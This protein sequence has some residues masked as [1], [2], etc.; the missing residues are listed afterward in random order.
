MPLKLDMDIKKL[1]GER[2]IS[3]EFVENSSKLFS[4]I[5]S[6]QIITNNSGFARELLE[7][8]GF[9]DFYPAQEDSLKEVE[10]IKKQIGKEKAVVGFGGGKA[11]DV[12]KKVSSDLNL[13]FIS[14]PTAPSH[15]GLVS[16]NSSL[17]DDT[18]KRISI[19]AKY[20]T[21]LIIPLH[22][23]KNTGDL[24]K[25]GIC[26]LISNLIALQD[27]S[28]AEK[29]GEK[30]D[31][32]YKELSFEAQKP[33]SFE[34]DKVLAHSL[35]MSG[36]SM[37]QTS[38]Y[39]SGS[40]HEVEKLLERKLKGKYLHGQLVGLGTLITARVYFIYADSFPELRFDPRALFEEIKQRMIKENIYDFVR[41]PLADKDFKAE[42]LEEVSEIRP[43]RYGLW[44]FVDSKKID[45]GEIVRDI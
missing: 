22:L 28:L 29:E 34:D 13:D 23:W 21:K 36:I 4:E 9:K 2:G 31:D 15:D 39:C 19:P 5:K 17:S 33:E 38:R 18:G 1:L 26:D 45:W 37:E 32:F 44:N 6:K 35:I 30:F 24:R 41:A 11:I 14:V 8:K 40:E 7:E 20:P 16:K 3:L 10:R 43:Q 27:L 42:F 25:A 12:A